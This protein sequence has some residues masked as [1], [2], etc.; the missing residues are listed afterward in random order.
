MSA[1]NGAFTG[2]PPGPQPPHQPHQPRWAWWV[3]GIVI[4]LVGIIVTVLVSRPDSSGD[5]SVAQAPAQS[6]AAAGSTDAHRS[7]GTDGSSGANPAAD[8][9]STE[10]GKGAQ[11]AKAAFG[12][13]VF[14][15]D[16]T[17]SGS[18]I[19]FDTAEP[20]VVA[21]ST[22]KGADVI[23]SAST[24]GAPDLFV[25]DSRMALA[26]PAGS[27]AAPTAEECAESVERNATY[28]LPATR[29]DFCLTTTEG[30]T[31]HLKVLTAP[32]A[33]LAKLEVTVWA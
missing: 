14:R 22:P 23:I 6:S 10:P 16:T 31:V 7:S 32:P 30:R 13:E 21:N 12:P 19:D 9:P 8:Q 26:P 28:T 20:L 3:V 1:D 11:A 25:P 17:N 18:Y 4:P 15:A 27:G 2:T 5:K 33:G 24:G 29:G